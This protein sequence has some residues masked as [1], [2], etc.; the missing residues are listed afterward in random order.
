MVLEEKRRAEPRFNY[1]VLA[2]D[3][4]SQVLERARTAVYDESKT[5][6]VPLSLKKRYMLKSKKPGTGLVRMKPEIR[7]KVSFERINFMDENY[8]VQNAIDVVFC[9]NVII[10]FER[11]I[12]ESILGKLSEHIRVGGWLILGHSETVIG[13]GMPLRGIAPTIYEKTGEM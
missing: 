3:L 2:S 8:P 5:E 7:A 13:M 1:R 4:S 11:R 10:Y 9:R 6:V 12:Q